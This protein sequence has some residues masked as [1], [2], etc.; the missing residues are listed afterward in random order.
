MRAALVSA[1][2]GVYRLN[3]GPVRGPAESVSSLLCAVLGRVVLVLSEAI[4]VLEPLRAIT[5]TPTTRGRVSLRVSRAHRHAM[6]DG[7]MKVIGITGGIG[8]GKSTAAGLL[9]DLGAYVVDA[10][11]VG[12]D[13]YRPGSEGWRRV[14]TEF[15]QQVVASDGTI[16]RKRLGAIVFSDRMALARLNALLHPLIG[17]EIRRLI[18]SKRAAGRTAPIVVEAAV[19]VEASWQSLVDEVW[20]VTADREAVI[21]RLAAQ[22]GLDPAAVQ[23]RIDSQLSDEERCRHATVVVRNDGTVDD[24]RA[25]LQR[26]WDE[27]LG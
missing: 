13:V 2:H 21:R 4:R 3:R 18:E 27:R 17:D 16:D 10:D 24:L 22:R 20:V 12:H 8:S 15:G 25:E 7:H 14:V 5:S 9:S 23:S 11:K 26:L 19:L 6:L 1:S